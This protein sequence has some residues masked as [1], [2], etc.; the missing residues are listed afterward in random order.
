MMVKVYRGTKDTL[1]NL[2]DAYFDGGLDYY[3]GK[4]M[5][6]AQEMKDAENYGANNFSRFGIVCQ[7]DIRIQNLATLFL[8]AETSQYFSREKEIDNFARSMLHINNFKGIDGEMEKLQES[9]LNTFN[10]IDSKYDAVAADDIFVLKNQ[11]CPINILFFNLYLKDE[12]SA[13]K[14]FKELNSGDL[15]GN[16][17]KGIPGENRD[18][19]SLILMASLKE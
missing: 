13:I 19:L 12:A 1:P 6:F 5:Y 9:R 17:I 7:Y 3:Y 8:D 14:I 16:A 15:E 11:S 10:Y 18:R 4:G 2:L